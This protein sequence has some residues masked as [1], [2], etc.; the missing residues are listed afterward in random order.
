MGKSLS[1]INDAI[2]DPFTDPDKL[3][4]YREEVADLKQELSE[5]RNHLQLMDVNEDEL[6]EMQF[7][8][9]Q[10]LFDTTVKIRKS[11]KCD[12]TK[13]CSLGGYEYWQWEWLQ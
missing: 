3:Q 6:Y 11:I 2:S 12:D 9:K 10:E 8:L 4:E 13:D 7:A 1:S 5:V